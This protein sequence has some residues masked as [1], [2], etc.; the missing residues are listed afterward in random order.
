VP[1]EASDTC[2]YPGEPGYAGA[3]EPENVE[4]A[5]LWKRYK[6]LGTWALPASRKLT[7]A[8]HAE[9]VHVLYELELENAR[10]KQAHPEVRMIWDEDG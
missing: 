3:L 1:C 9:L 7:D 6:V 5:E 8:Q 2:P 4:L 10:L